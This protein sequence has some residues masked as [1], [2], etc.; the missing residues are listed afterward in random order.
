MLDYHD[1]NYYSFDR[2]NFNLEEENILI[3][4]KSYNSDD[5]EKT[6][7]PSI[8]DKAKR[9]FREED[10]IAYLSRH[11]SLNSILANHLNCDPKALIIEKNEFGKPYLKENPFYFN[12]SKSK[13]FF[14]ILLSKVECGVDIE[15]IRDVSNMKVVADLYFHTEE[16]KFCETGFFDERFLTVWTRKEA[17]L[18]AI[19]TGLTNDLSNINTLED[20]IQLNYLNLNIATEVSNQFIVSACFQG[21]NH[22]SLKKFKL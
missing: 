7:H 6:L 9:F 17:V 10:R 1:L 11:N 2:S 19:G 14:C 18:K 13:E 22:F 8:I 4:G 12:L 15:V 3:F 5:F 20:S 16:K 21:T